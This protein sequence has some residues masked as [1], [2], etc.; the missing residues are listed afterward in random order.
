VTDSDPR[1][2]ARGI[3]I[4]AAAVTA[5]HDGHLLTLVDTPGHVDFGIE[6][7]RS[8]R[9][10]DGAVVVID[11]VSG[12]EPQTET[13]WAQADRFGVP[14]IVFINKIDRDGADFEAS[15][16]SL[17]ETFG[18]SAAPLVIP[19]PAGTAVL[20][21]VRGVAR[22]PGPRSSDRLRAL[23]GDE[24]ALVARARERLAER[25]A[26]HDAEVL[27][28]FVGGE[29][30]SD[31]V[32]RASL[33]R[34]THHRTLIPVLAGSAKLG[35][36]ITA[37][38]DA[39]VA[40]LPSP[41]DA[42]ST[43]AREASEAGLVAFAF[44]SVHDEFGARIFVRVY[45]GTLRRGAHVLLAGAGRTARIGRLVHVFGERVEDVDAIGPGEIAAVL[46]L[47][48]TTGE[49]LCDPGDR[50]ELEGL[51]VPEPVVTVALEPVGSEARARLGSCL[52]RLV[53]DDPSLRLTSNLE[54][55]ETLLSG[56]GELHLDVTLNKLR[57][58]AGVQVR[59]SA[60]RV[61]YRETITCASEA[62]GEFIKQKGGPGHYGHVLLGVEPLSRSAGFEFV[63]AS[64]GG[65]VPKAFV[66]AVEAGAREAARLGVLGGYPLVDVRVS[67][68]GGSFH[69]KDSNEHA[70]AMAARF[71]FQE[72]A[73]RAE[74]VYLE[75]VMKLEVVTP[76]A[77][78]GDVLSD[79]GTR[80]AR[81]SGL[82]TRG[83]RNTVAA[84]VP[85]AELLGYADVL[86][87]RTQG[88]ASFSM[89]LDGYEVVPAAVSGRVKPA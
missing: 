20:D 21:V 60:P 67:L 51:S 19:A 79:L 54:T 39:V 46:G 40:L 59:A 18:V 76:E 7:E 33:R 5:R 57:D 71:A 42:R 32:L 23:A 8:L 35:L 6:V 17:E 36:G 30:L 72:A 73:R 9:V 80:R 68:R 56:L 83:A 65:V 53:A 88:R 43:T 45:S 75:P 87:S 11:A 85:L 47:V 84:R 1:E 58:D 13:V 63:D 15:L 89:K 49:T 37:L 64:L 78:L 24:V 69:E 38:L 10:L 81:V 22:E 14:R 44:K 48:A 34:A 12:V 16:R 27:A 4:G 29:P 66:P 70:F 55:G 41:V 28:A 82:G 50:V 62:E 74:P 25:L 26:D 77:R 3:T 31:D 52:S 86:R 2:K 61:A